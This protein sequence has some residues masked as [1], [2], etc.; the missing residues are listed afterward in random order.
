VQA[1]IVVPHL[2]LG[3]LSRMVS[4]HFLRCFIPK[5]PS[6]GFLKLFQVVANVAHGD[7]LKSIA[8]MLGV[9]ILLTEGFH[10]I[11]VGKMFL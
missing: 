2:F 7:I 1:L 9:S 11:V 4:E 10:C 3:G 8:L 6:L 5:D